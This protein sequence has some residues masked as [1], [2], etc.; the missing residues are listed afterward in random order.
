MAKNKLPATIEKRILITG[1]TGFLGA[2][3]VRNFLAAGVLRLEILPG[4]HGSRKCRRRRPAAR[5]NESFPAARRRRRAAE[6]DQTRARFPRP[7][8]SL[9]PKR[10]A[11]FCRCRRCCGGFYFRS[12]E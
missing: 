10:R 4:A 12:G 8:N 7:Q 11:E 2:H 9:Q 5:D 6:F 3:I 1:G